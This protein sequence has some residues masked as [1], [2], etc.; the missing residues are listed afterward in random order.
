MT[1]RG[2]HRETRDLLERK[3]HHPD[4]SQLW[5]QLTEIVNN[6]AYLRH[7]VAVED[8]GVVLDAGGNV[9]VAAAFFAV[10]F[11]ASVHSF[12]PAPP[13]F[14]LLRRN[15]EHFPACTAHPYGLAASA[16]HRTITYYPEATALS[17]LHADPAA[18]T[19]LVRMALRNLGVAEA[20]IDQ[21]IPA[22]YRALEFECELRTV[23]SVLRDE[24][25]ERVDLLK[26]DVEGAEEDVLLGVD[27]EDWP[28]IRQV[29]AEV[30]DRDGRLERVTNILDRQGLKGT[31]DQDPAMRGTD[32]WMLYALRR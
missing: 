7:G 29:V 8:G 11:G 17:G 5:Y 2:S 26:I 13:A 1:E 16:G 21:R 30:H 18:D 28:R 32:V 6:R 3:L 9:G 22:D 23:S 12:E 24:D 20:E 31:V 15:L 19:N 4:R 27:D 10:E 14:E 25:I